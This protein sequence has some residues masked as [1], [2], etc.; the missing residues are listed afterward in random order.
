MRN[1]MQTYEQPTLPFGEDGSTYSPADSPA[2]RSVSPENGGA[3]P[4]TVISGRRCCE[5]YARFVPAGSWERTFTES[6]IGRGGWF[7]TRCALTWRMQASPFSRLFF[8]LVPSA[9]PTGGTGRGLLPTVQTQGLKQCRDGKTLF[10]PTDLLP[11]PTAID[12]GAGRLNRSLSPGAAE[13]PTL[14]LAAR[15]YLLPTPTVNDAANS[16]IPPSQFRRDNLAGA[17]LRGTLPTPKANDF[18]SGMMNR[19]GTKHTQQL[20]DTV[21]GRATLRKL[22]QHAGAPCNLETSCACS[23]YRGCARFTR[24]CRYSTSRW[25]EADRYD[26]RTNSGPAESDARHPGKTRTLR[27]NAT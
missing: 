18:R 2:S 11:T 19:V 24:R 12:S 26:A 15:R 5:Q 27:C 1:N 20:N 4:T 21:E 9:L 16:S 17:W 10:M 7:S 25:R 22:F 14:A 23:A 3:Q 6:L 8:R 13:R